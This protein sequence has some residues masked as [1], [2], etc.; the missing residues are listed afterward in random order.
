MVFSPGVSFLFKIHAILTD[1]VAA[2]SAI[3]DVILAFLPWKLIWSLRMKLKEKIGVV[4][5]MS[6]GVL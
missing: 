1:S 5:A 2:Y 3:M 6:L 4:L